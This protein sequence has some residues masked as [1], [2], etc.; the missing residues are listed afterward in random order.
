MTVRSLTNCPPKLRGA[1][2]KWLFEISAGVY[3]GNVSARVRELLWLRV[4]ENCGSGRAVMVFSTDNEQGF[5]FLVYGTVWFPADFDGIRIMKIPSAKYLEKNNSA[6]GRKTPFE[7]QKIASSV[8]RKNGLGSGFVVLDVETTGLDIRNDVLTEIG[9]ILVEDGEIRKE[10]QVLVNIGEHPLPDEVIQLNGLTRELLAEKGVDP[11][12][13]IE[14]LRDFIG[15]STVVGY[16][17]LAFDSRVLS[18]ACRR[19]GIPKFV[20]ETRDVL[21]AARQRLRSL[22]SYSLYDVARFLQIELPVRQ[23]RALDDCTLIWK[24]MEALR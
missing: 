19:A 5:D 10:Y 8:R 24:V 13:A 15:T 12:E 11:K 2:T 21:L 7:K 3:V 22:E 9:A 6:L 4:R 1:L 20:E 18:M 17:I 16:N 14:G 23:H